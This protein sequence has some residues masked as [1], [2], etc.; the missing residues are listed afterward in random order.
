MSAIAVYIALP[1]LVRS[2]WTAYCVRETLAG[3]KAGGVPPAQT[4]AW[5]RAAGIEEALFWNGT[6]IDE[7]ALSRLACNSEPGSHAPDDSSESGSTGT[8]ADMIFWFVGFSIALLSVLLFPPAT[9]LA[10]ECESIRQSSLR[11]LGG[12]PITVSLRCAP[13]SMPVWGPAEKA[14][15]HALTNLVTALALVSAATA[16]AKADGSGLLVTALLLPAGL[17]FLAHGAGTAASGRAGLPRRVRRAVPCR[18]ACFAPLPALLPGRR[19][20]C[21][22]VAHGIGC[23]SR[24]AYGVLVVAIGAAMLALL[25]F[26]FGRYGAAWLGI[27]PAPVSA[28]PGFGREVPFSMVPVVMALTAVALAAGVCAALSAAFTC[29]PR[30]PCVDVTAAAVGGLAWPGTVLAMCAGTTPGGVKDGN[31]S[32]WLDLV[33]TCSMMPLAWLA[34]RA[35]IRSSGR[36]QKDDG[37]M[38]QLRNPI[39]LAW[40]AEQAAQ[41]KVGERVAAITH[42]SLFL[43]HAPPGV[44]GRWSTR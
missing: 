24:V 14:A 16:V 20:R 23:A 39:I 18:S 5:G 33:S 4:L 42:I 9:I 31:G 10:C 22:A 41:G 29:G 38:Q 13:S 36:G 8:T 25:A 21:G 32:L 12:A 7:S 44:L 35:W 30:T 11:G 6:A 3:L 34:V 19:P 27:S 2:S 26:C 28:V 37:Y 1:L 43:R 15:S 40:R 17:Y